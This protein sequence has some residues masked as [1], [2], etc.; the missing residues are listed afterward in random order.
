MPTFHAYIGTTAVFLA[1]FGFQLASLFDPKWVQ[2]KSPE[3]YLT[4]TNYGLFHKCSTLTADCRRF[5]QKTWGD[6]DQDKGTSSGWVNL[7]LEWRIAAGMAVA[8]T[9]AGLWVLA[10][11]AT[12]F[13]TGERFRA[14]GWKHI[15]GLIGIFAGL[16]IVSMALVAHVA[17]T[18]AMFAHHHFGPSFIFSNVS[19]GLAAVLAL[20]VIL[21]ARYGAQGYIALE[22]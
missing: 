2:Y 17:G 12:V 14:Q 6:C 21:Y 8:S 18:S 19:W 13:Y 20:G 3:P 10:G 5:P 9:V 11:L 15:L 1:T 4:E 16:Q 7:C 22:E